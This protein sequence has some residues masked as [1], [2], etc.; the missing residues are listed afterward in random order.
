MKGEN[1]RHLL[2]IVLL[3]TVILSTGCTGGNEKISV[4]TTQIPTPTNVIPIPTNTLC[5]KKCN[6]VCYDPRKQ[7]CCFGIILDGFWREHSQPGLCYNLSYTTSIE[8]QSEWYCGGV[9][10]H[11]ND[12]LD[13]CNGITYNFNTTHCCNGKIVTGG[14]G[15]WL[16][17]GNSCYDLD[18][19]SCC[20]GQIYNGFNRCCKSDNNSLICPS[21]QQCCDD[22][23]KGPTC[24]NPETQWC[25]ISFGSNSTTANANKTRK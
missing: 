3:V 12:N 1:M 20:N 23:D 6:D 19:Q 9:I 16:N 15:Y 7:S 10:F 22:K 8:S 5:Q 2:L 14:E 13:C 18:N 11:E 24:Y 25:Q 4:P 17:C 21:G